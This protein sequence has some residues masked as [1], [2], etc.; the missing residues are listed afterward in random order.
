MS[1]IAHA[2]GPCRAW[3]VQGVLDWT[4]L[5]DL[6]KL[7]A[8]GDR[9]GKRGS[10]GLNLNELHLYSP[11]MPQLRRLVD[12]PLRHLALSPARSLRAL[13]GLADLRLTSLMLAYLRRD[14]LVSEALSSQSSLAHHR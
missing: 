1:C 14:L 3:D 5:P 12:L 9:F 11:Q 7:L 2:S 13:D 10:A 6:Q 8:Y 4:A